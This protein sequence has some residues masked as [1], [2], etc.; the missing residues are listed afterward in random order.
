MRQENFR[1]AKKKPAIREAIVEFVFQ[2]VQRLSPPGRFLG[3]DAAG[4]WKELGLAE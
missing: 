1:V 4:S 3:K 2:V